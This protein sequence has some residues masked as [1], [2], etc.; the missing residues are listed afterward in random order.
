MDVR[1]IG[2]RVVFLDEVFDGWVG[3]GVGEVG[4]SGRHDGIML[5]RVRGFF[6]CVFKVRVLMKD[7]GE[8]EAVGFNKIRVGLFCSTPKVGAS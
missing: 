2:N 6:L 5:S 8:G 3:D 4:K 1:I 7:V